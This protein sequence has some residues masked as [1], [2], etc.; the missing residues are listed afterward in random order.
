[1][2]PDCS[3]SPTLPSSLSISW[4]NTAHIYGLKPPISISTHPWQ[5]FQR[6]LE[7]LLGRPGWPEPLAEPECH[8]PGDRPGAWEAAAQ[9]EAGAASAQR[10]R[11]HIFLYVFRLHGLVGGVRGVEGAEYQPTKRTDPSAPYDAPHRPRPQWRALPPGCRCRRDAGLRAG[12]S[13]SHRGTALGRSSPRQPARLRP[14]PPLPG[15]GA[16]R[17]STDSTGRAPLCAAAPEGPPGKGPA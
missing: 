16:P 2:L 6:R 11:T 7:L 13:R 10:A 12:L 9:D 8:R 1:M 5:L 3:V 17:G 14:Q 4:E 15:R